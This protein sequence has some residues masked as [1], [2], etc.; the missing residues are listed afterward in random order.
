VFKESAAAWRGRASSNHTG[1]DAVM[2]EL[3]R[4]TFDRAVRETR[5][6]VGRPDTVALQLES[7]LDRFGEV[8]P[9][10]QLL[11]GNMPHVMAERS[12]RLFAQEVMPRFQ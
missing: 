1:Y 3:D 8:E 6:F 5:A 2:N 7:I 12:L 4:M 9:S 11:Y 10:L